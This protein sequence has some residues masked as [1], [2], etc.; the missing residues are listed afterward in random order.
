MKRTFSEGILNPSRHLFLIIMSHAWAYA[1]IGNSN[2]KS[3]QPP[4]RLRGWHISAKMSG[5]K[6]LP[7]WSRH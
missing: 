3:A 6:L 4:E 7:S 5:M 2:K 1:K